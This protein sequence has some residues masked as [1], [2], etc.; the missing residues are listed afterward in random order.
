M[1]KSLSNSHVCI[2]RFHQNYSR[3][4]QGKQ[5]TPKPRDVY[6]CAREL[7][8]RNKKHHTQRSAP[9]RQSSRKSSMSTEKKF[10]SLDLTTAFQTKTE[11]RGWTAF[12]EALYK[13]WITDRYKRCYT[14][15]QRNQSTLQKN[16]RWYI[17]QVL[18]AAQFA[19]ITA[20][21]GLSASR[22]EN[23]ERRQFPLLQLSQH[24]LRNLH[25]RPQ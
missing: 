1:R 17:I 4:R 19:Q 18:T 5:E 2:E 10:T 21:G 13:F 16:R 9:K 15:S 22:F 7:Q 12:V 23:S 24:I 11:G 20:G 3:P 6:A 8:K 25:S 14:Q